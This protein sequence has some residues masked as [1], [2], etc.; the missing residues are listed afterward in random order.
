MPPEMI[1]LDGV[2]PLVRSNPLE[3]IM[4]FFYWNSS[5]EVGVP[6][7]DKQHQEL[8]DLINELGSAITT[9]IEVP[10]F[11]DLTQ[12]LRDYINFHF[13]DEERVFEQSSM[14]QEEQANHKAK[15]RF[16]EEKVAAVIADKDWSDSEA[17]EELFDFLVTWLVKHILVADRNIPQYLNGNDRS[18][19]KPDHNKPEDPDD[20]HIMRTL[21]HALNESEK[22]FRLLSDNAPVMIWIADQNG[23][24]IFHNRVWTDVIGEDVA[25]DPEIWFEVIH[26]EDRAAYKKHFG[27]LI[28]KPEPAD[29][30]YR[31][32]NKK[33]DYRHFLERVLPRE[34]EDGD[35]MGLIASTVDVTS[36]K[37]A[38]ELLMQANITLEIEVEKRTEEIRKLMLT[39]TL[40]NTKN[41]RFL[42][43]Q[44]ETE[45]IR[46]Q[47]YNSPLTLIFFDI[48]HFKMVNDTYGHR[49]GDNVL[50]AT[51]GN[52]SKQ[53]RDCDYLCRYG[54]EE[55][56]ALLPETS[57]DRAGEIADRVLAIIRKTKLPDLGK[58]ITISAGVGEWQKGESR[59]DFLER[60]DKALYAAKDA[61]RDR[62]S[63]AGQS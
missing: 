6:R 51:A 37:Q 25:H 28:E 46:S 9:Q 42:M 4:Q 31:V 12:R 60:C 53:L 11:D 7:I 2:R 38:E 63:I 18:V 62:I 55:F 36:L 35:F 23:K 8:I 61:G 19:Q 13:R 20:F 33:G 56:I 29:F 45:I 58:A 39:D 27:K 15:H 49:A 3:Y 16:F 10:K 24:R 48:D 43:D 1:H 21:I 40:T 26:P 59:H 52:I 5:F 22:R 17:A 30:E 54:G 14:P 32:K 57:L 41:R 44:L 47:R 34:E 50:T